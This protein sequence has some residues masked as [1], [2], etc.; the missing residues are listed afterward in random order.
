MSS[1]N[2]VRPNHYRQGK[3]ETINIIKNSMSPEEFKGFLKG[4]VFKYMSRY[5]FKNGI[6]DLKKAQW[7]LAK[8]IIEEGK[9]ANS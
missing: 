6:E 1:D 7:Y 8:L 4:N 5:K 2:V 9:D 3:M